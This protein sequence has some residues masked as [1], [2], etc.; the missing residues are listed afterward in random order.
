MAENVQIDGTELDR[1]QKAA[2]KLRDSIEKAY[3]QCEALQQS[4]TV[5]GWEG[6]TNASF[7]TYLELIKQYH[8]DLKDAADLQCQALENLT[9]YRYDFMN[10]ALVKEVRHL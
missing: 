3:G 10:D 5:D 6:K 2:R 1:A 8:A 4:A 9:G 7:I